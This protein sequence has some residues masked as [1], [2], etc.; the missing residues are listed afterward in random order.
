LDRI[1]L[2]L[3]MIASCTDNNLINLKILE[4]LYANQEELI[5]DFQNNDFQ[6]NDFQNIDNFLK[7]NNIDLNLDKCLNKKDLLENILRSR[8]EANRDFDIKS[9]PT[10]IIGDVIISGN[11]K[12]KLINEIEKKLKN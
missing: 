2:Q 10:F 6:N 9:T 8:R 4:I 11:N 7:K 1:A 5:N 3:A 12:N